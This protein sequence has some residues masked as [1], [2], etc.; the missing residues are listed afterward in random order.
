M[1]ILS[2]IILE[3]LF[4][5]EKMILIEINTLL[6]F[7]HYLIDLPILMATVLTATN[8]IPNNINDNAQPIE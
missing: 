3:M 4:L 8:M 5:W 6:F 7:K 2:S 1:E